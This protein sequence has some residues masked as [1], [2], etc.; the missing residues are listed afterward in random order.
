[1]I[2]TPAVASKILHLGEVAPRERHVAALSAFEAL[3]VGNALEVVNDHDPKPLY[4]QLQ[5][6]APA[7]FSW[8]YLQR[9]P[10]VWRVTIRKLA[11]SHGTGGCC[12]ACGGGA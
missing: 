3:E 9:G 10:D 2:T 7:G 4:F 5:A 6:R 11:R 1:M 12:G 8:D